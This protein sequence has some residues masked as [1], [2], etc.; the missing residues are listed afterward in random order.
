LRVH[1]RN[2]KHLMLQADV[3]VRES[4]VR[5]TG[6]TRIN[7]RAIQ[8]RLARQQIQKCVANTDRI[9]P[10]HL[11]NF[12]SQ[13]PEPTTHRFNYVCNG[14]MKSLEFLTVTKDASVPSA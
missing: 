5:N 3:E 1:C 2:D 11:W 7:S 14:A 6:A 4:L 8:R 10:G 13:E 12:R 9:W